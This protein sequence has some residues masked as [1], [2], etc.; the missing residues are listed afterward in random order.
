MNQPQDDTP[1]TDARENEPCPLG[2]AFAEWHRIKYRNLACDLERS[3]R[4]AQKDAYAGLHKLFDDA[5]LFTRHSRDSGKTWQR[6]P[7]ERRIAIAISVCKDEEDTHEKLLKAEQQLA[8][9]Q[10]ERDGWKELADQRMADYNRMVEL[11]NDA[12][13]ELA[14]LREQ[15][16][17]REA[18]IANLENTP[19]EIEFRTLAEQRNAL[20]ADARRLEIARKA[21]E[22]IAYTRIG[23]GRGAIGVELVAHHAK[24][25][26]LNA[27]DALE[28]KS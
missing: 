7:I 4:E 17:E 15:I 11:R 21:L 2:M 5:D 3:L 25:T 6:Y 9:A 14:A 12:K 28:Q 23:E 10:K 19:V 13:V 24:N 16:A 18:R 20:A 8:E 27:L 1:L 26:A 22:N